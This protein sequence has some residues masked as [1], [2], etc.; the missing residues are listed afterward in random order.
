M[1]YVTIGEGWSVDWSTDDTYGD[2]FTFQIDV[3][4]DKPHMAEVTDIMDRCLQ[5]LI[6]ESN[7]LSVAGFGVVIVSK[8]LAQTFR[9]PDGKTRHGVLRI[10]MQLEQL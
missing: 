3:W 4:S 8:K 5:A 2:D 10:R 9:D 6:D 1:P 7:P